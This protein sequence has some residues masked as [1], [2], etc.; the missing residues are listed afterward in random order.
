MVSDIVKFYLQSNFRKYLRGKTAGKGTPTKIY[1]ETALIEVGRPEDEELIIDFLCRLGDVKID[2]WYD[3]HYL[4]FEPGTFDTWISRDEFWQKC[5]DW[6]EVDDFR[7]SPVDSYCYYDLIE[8]R[9]TMFPPKSGIHILFS[10]VNILF[11]IEH[12]LQFPLVRTQID[13]YPDKSR[14][15]FDKIRRSGIRRHPLFP[16]HPIL[17]EDLTTIERWTPR[18]HG[19]IV[20]NARYNRGEIDI[21]RTDGSN[22]MTI[23]ETVN[24]VRDKAE[25]G[26]YI[27]TGYGVFNARNFRDIE[28][29]DIENL[30]VVDSENKIFI[31]P[32]GVSPAEEPL[33]GVYRDK[34]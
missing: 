2:N 7:D 16:E 34:P 17:M 12:G 29:P 5:D 27:R 14:W 31:R 25:R 33:R 30:G 15:Y 3:Q 13:F 20:V 24:F 28:I 19:E 11:E 32:R 6:G 10:P 1:I 4:K 22:W 23:M 26:D 8:E 21:V 9:I 18:H